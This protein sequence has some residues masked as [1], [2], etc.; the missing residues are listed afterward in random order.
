MSRATDYLSPYGPCWGT[1][2][3]FPYRDSEG[4]V[5][6]RNGCHRRGPV[7]EAGEGIHL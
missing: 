4:E 5:I 7:G 6:V 3:G 1:W 2:R